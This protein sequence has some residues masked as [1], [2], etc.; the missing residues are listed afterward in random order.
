MKKRKSKKWVLSAAWQSWCSWSQAP[1]WPWWSSHCVAWVSQS[2]L[3]NWSWCLGCDDKKWTWRS[4]CVLACLGYRL[5]GLE[6]IELYST[7][8]WSLG[9]LRPRFQQIPW[10][11]H[12]SC[13]HPLCPWVAK[14]ERALLGLF[15]KKVY[16][17]LFVWA[18]LAL[19]AWVLSVA[20]S[21]AGL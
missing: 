9:S 6:T 1:S 4:I 11:L 19:A 2:S 20:M 12:E 16:I 7:W 3:R 13:H 8:F 14:G 10:L 18:M 5:C 15:L 21:A 17:T